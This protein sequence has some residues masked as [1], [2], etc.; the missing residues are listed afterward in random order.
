M[1]AWQLTGRSLCRSALSPRRCFSMCTRLDL[2]RSHRGRPATPSYCER[3]NQFR[4]LRCAKTYCQCRAVQ[5][6]S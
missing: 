6:F 2:R 5:G 3:S 4:F 1:L